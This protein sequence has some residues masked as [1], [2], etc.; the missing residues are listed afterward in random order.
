MTELVTGEGKLYLATYIDL[1][2]K[3]VGRAL[4][5][6]HRAEL[7][8]VALRLAAGREGLRRAASCTPIAAAR[9]DLH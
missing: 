3:V 5:D 1:A 8:I 6:H 7:P 9:V 4:A 2:T